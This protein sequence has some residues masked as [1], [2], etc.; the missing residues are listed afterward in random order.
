VKLL[1]GSSVTSDDLNNELRHRW[2]VAVAEGLLSSS[3]I[4]DLPLI[5]TVDEE[6]LANVRRVKPAE[7][8]GLPFHVTYVQ[9]GDRI[10]RSGWECRVTA[11]G[12]TYID[13]DGEPPSS[14][15]AVPHFVKAPILSEAAPV[16]RILPRGWDRRETPAG[17][18]YY[19]DHNTQSTS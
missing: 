13:H 18:A 2:S 6:A 8:E 7:R 3:H 11:Q 12:T 16:L 9:R 5:P 1:C 4:L 15:D 17:R 10:F 14:L 19:V